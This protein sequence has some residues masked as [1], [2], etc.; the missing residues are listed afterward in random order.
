MKTYQSPTTDVQLISP[1]TYMCQITSLTEG[2]QPNE[3]LAP[4][5]L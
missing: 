4:I 3:Q 1:F 5:R 2:E